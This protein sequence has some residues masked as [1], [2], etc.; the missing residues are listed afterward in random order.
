VTVE[1][2]SFATI[3][4]MGVITAL[5]RFAGFAL[6]RWIPLTPR[7]EAFLRAVPVAVI[8]AFLAPILVTAG[9]LE[10]AAVAVACGMFLTLRNDLLAVAA[11]MGTAAMVRNWPF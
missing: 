11:A 8:G 9:P 5:T 4:G 7:V 1:L 3:A 6:M 10:W 2:L